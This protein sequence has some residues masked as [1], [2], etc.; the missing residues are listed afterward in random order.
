MEGEISLVLLLNS[1]AGAACQGGKEDRNSTHRRL[2]SGLFE[3][4]AFRTS[5][6]R[7]HRNA[8]TTGGVTLRRC[9]NPTLF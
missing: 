2:K 9:W 8:A 6:T 3:R 1:Y 7:K 5:S 4:V